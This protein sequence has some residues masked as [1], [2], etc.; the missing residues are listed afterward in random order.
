MNILRSLGLGSL[1]L[2]VG[3]AAPGCATKR[4]VRDLQAQLIAAQARQDSL[5]RVLSRQNRE[6]LDSVRVTTDLLVR[7]RG[8]LGH[9]LL[10]VAQQLVQVQEL[11]GQSQRRLSDLN[12]Q[13]QQQRQQMQSA[14]QPDTGARPMQL[15]ADANVQAGTPPAS[16][17]ADLYQ[18]GQMQLQNGA[19]GTARIAFQQL[20]RNFPGD[21]LAPAAQYGIAESYAGEDVERALREFDRVV[22]QYPS[23]A[24]A[25]AALLR[26]GAL[27]QDRGNVARAREYFQR[28]IAR[29]PGSP[30][31]TQA[32]T[33]IKRLG[34][35]A[36][37][38]PKS[39]TRS[40]SKSRRS[41][42]AAAQHAAG[43]GA[44]GG[45]KKRKQH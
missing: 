3:A 36:A 35:G 4:D 41:V 10:D 29:Y 9:Q 34:T 5:F 8:E 25:P 45:A 11:T 44:H 28:I 30:E 23:S 24:R 33:R 32:R 18:L 22:E 20:L 14:A 1:A 6:V 17:A 43:T 12:T 13:L 39:G 19:A 26:A 15:P 16:N 42:R 38:R 31:A 2:V 40:R 7:V 27:Q 37:A 21:S